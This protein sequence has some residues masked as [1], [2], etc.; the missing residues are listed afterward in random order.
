MIRRKEQKDEIKKINQSIT[1]LMLIIDTRFL[2]A[3]SLSL[4]ILFI[5]KIVAGGFLNTL[6]SVKL[7]LG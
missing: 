4:H 5:K 1:I 2:S 6:K 3:T 7:T